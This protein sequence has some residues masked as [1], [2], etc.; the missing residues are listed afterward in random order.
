MMPSMLV[1]LDDA[2]G[3]F[4]PLNDFR[5]VF[6]QR[7]GACTTLERIE[8][9]F[10]HQADAL[11]VPAH[12]IELTQHRHPDASINRVEPSDTTAS[13][14]LINGRCLVAGMESELRTLQPGWKLM[15]PNGRIVA[16]HSHL[17]E[18]EAFI[19][20][21]NNNAGLEELAIGLDAVE[22][23]RDEM[24]TRPWNIITRLPQ[25]IMHD[26]TH[27]TLPAVKHDQTV[28]PQITMTGQHTH[29]LHL[30]DT[31]NLMP[32]I[33]VNL[34]QGPVV[35]DHGAT[36]QPFVTLEGPCYVGMNSTICSHAHLRPNTA[37]GPHCKFGGEINHS[38]VQAYSNKAHLGYLGNSIVGEWCNLGANTNV[39][40]IKNT[41]GSVRVRLNPED[42][43]MEDTGL[44]R[45]GPTFG[46]F[47]RT[48]IGTHILTGR[49]IPSGVMIAGLP[50]AP[51]VTKPFGFY[52]SNGDVDMH[53]M[54]PMLTTFRRMMAKHDVD[55]SVAMERRIWQMMEESM[56]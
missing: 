3:R 8:K 44:N 56:A 25:T 29:C 28:P 33:V 6:D 54:E 45:L 49:I 30:A 20:K 24:I 14:M 15:Q 16:I 37:I 50:F 35:I 41:Y 55:L 26:L 4:N 10:D 19:E 43:L 7:T 42:D 38:V 53:E 22:L 21:L 36:I 5:A 32:H 51:K 39:S 48:G 1:V 31:V 9:L 11:F 27:T 13:V 46:D 52:T 2:Q 17:G 47:V 40:N 34:E 23:S 18:H 12:L